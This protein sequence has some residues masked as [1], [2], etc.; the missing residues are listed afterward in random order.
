M[1]KAL[2]FFLLMGFSVAL[3]RSALAQPGQDLTKG[4]AAMDVT[5]RATVTVLVDNV[6]GGGPMLGEWGAA[7]LINTDKHQILLDT[8]GGLTLIGNARSL[9]VDLTRTEAIVI[10]HGHGDHTGGLSAVLDDS[11]PVDLFVHPN[12]FETRYFKGESG[13]EAYSFPFTRQ[14]TI[15]RVLNLVETEKPTVICEGVMVT[16]QIPRSNEYEDTGLRGVAYLDSGLTID[17]PVLDD[18]AVFFRAPEG[19]VI[20]LGCGHAGLVNTMDYVSKLTGEKRIYAVIGGTHLVSASPSRMQKT[21]EALRKYDVKKIMLSHCTGLRA[22]AR[23]AN[24]FPEKCSWPA[25]GTVI[26]FGK[27]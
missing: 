15:Q 24:T 20:I 19:I 8:G 3:W 1:K 25:S 4:K 27:E 26:E 2:P 5:P 9:G 22:Y 7:F 11:G 21:V 14:E 12:V 16:G 13:A 6:A 10:S 17:D 23:L 18:Q